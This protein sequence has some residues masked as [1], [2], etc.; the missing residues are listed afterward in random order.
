MSDREA[1]KRAAKAGLLAPDLWD[2]FASEPFRQGLVL[3]YA[4]IPDHSK[5][6]F[7]TLASHRGD[8]PELGQMGADGIDHPRSAGG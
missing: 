6:L 7:D 1:S 3:G 8:D 5:Q 4:G 2:Y